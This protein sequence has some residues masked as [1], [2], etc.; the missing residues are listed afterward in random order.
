MREDTRFLGDHPLVIWH[1]VSFRAKTND[2]PTGEHWRIQVSECFDPKFWSYSQRKPFQAAFPRLRESALEAAAYFERHQDWAALHEALD[3]AAQST[4][5]M[6]QWQDGLELIKRRLTLP[7]LSSDEW[8]DLVLW[9]AEA[10]FWGSDYTSCI[11]VLQDALESLR[12]GHPIAH[13]G[14]IVTFTRSLTWSTT[15]KVHPLACFKAIT[16]RSG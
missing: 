8:A 4:I 13:L 14:G 12:P 1:M 10:H 11:S 16:R 3:G 6:R 15:T 7:D 2:R 5:Y 9:L